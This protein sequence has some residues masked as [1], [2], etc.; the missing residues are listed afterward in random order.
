MNCISHEV[1]LTIQE[2]GTFDRMFRWSV[3]AVIQDI[4]GFTGVMQGRKKLADAETL[5]DLPTAAVPWAA[6]GDS[7]VYV[8]DDGVDPD[9]QGWFRVYIND[10][11]T[12]GLCESNK[13]IEGAYTLFLSSAEGEVVL[14]MFGKLIIL[15]SAAR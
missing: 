12:T 3:D 15:A 8:E 13:D 1:D 6:D 11:D 7:G 2:G 5:V 10:T 9:T 4:A 14:K